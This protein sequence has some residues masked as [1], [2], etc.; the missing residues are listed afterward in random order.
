MAHHHHAE[1]TS[2][3]RARVLVISSTRTLETDR[4]GPVLVELAEAGGVEVLGREVLPDDEP[5]IRARVVEIARQ[6]EVD[7]L[8]LTGGTGISSRDVTCE[9]L[10]SC[11]DKTLPGFGEIFRSLSFAEIG[12]GAM[13]SRAVAG[14][15]ARTLVF[16]LPGSPAACRLAM[17]KL[18]LPQL[19]HLRG[20][21]QKEHK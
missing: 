18:I 2:P 12:A 13:L 17:E 15:T 4:G 19:G 9:A 14:V 11:L 3:P 6:G 1:P 8:L 21:I 20:E 7:L 10:E 16:A 5:A